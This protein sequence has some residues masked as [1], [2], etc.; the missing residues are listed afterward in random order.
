MIVATTLCVAEDRVWDSW[1]NPMKNRILCSVLLLSFHIA[2]VATHEARSADSSTAPADA[3]SAQDVSSAPPAAG[4]VR[5]R[6]A[7][8]LAHERQN[9]PDRN[10]AGIGEHIVVRVDNLQSLLDRAQCKGRGPDCQKQNVALFLDGRRIDRI[11]P[12]S[13]APQPGREIL[14][15]RLDRNADNDR[16]WADLL[17][18]PPLTESFFYKPTSVSVGLENGYAEETDVTAEHF[19]LRRVREIRFWICVI[20][21]GLL[22]WLFAMLAH[23]SDILRDSGEPPTGLAPNGR[24]HRRPFS[25]SR[26]QMAFWFFLVVISYLLIWQITNAIDIVNETVLA[27]I[28]IGAGTALG[29][30]AV[31]SGKRADAENIVLNLRTELAILQQ[32]AAALSAQLSAVPP[33]DNAAALQQQ[34]AE[35]KGRITGVEAQLANAQANV[36]PL[37]SRGFLWDILS[38]A[39]GVSFHRFQ[40]V[41]WTVILGVIFIDSVYMRLSM[42]VFGATLLALQGISAGTYLGFKIPEQQS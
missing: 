37:V 30:A 7:Y 21:I 2:F 12:V 27:L 16:I 23:H 41:T 19:R 8:R 14:Q 9:D 10:S 36:Q 42:P 3:R 4:A 39:H 17:G 22:I 24:P 20:A 38:D 6:D 31:D 1:R 34:I 25:L 18:A 29:A 40:M 26:C 13:G 33:P 15:F 5:V 11:I 28:G 32:T 35:K